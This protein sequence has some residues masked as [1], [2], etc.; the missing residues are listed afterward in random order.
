MSSPGEQQPEHLLIRQR[1]EKASSLREKGIDPFAGKFERTGTLAEIRTQHEK[2]ALR[3]EVKAA[4]RITARRGHGKST[5]LDLHDGTAKLQVNATLDYLGE[6]AYEVLRHLVDIG[7]IVGVTGEIGTTRTGEVTIFATKVR[8]LTKTLRPLPEKFHGLKDIELRHRKRSLDLISN[9]EVID[10]FRTRSRMVQRI[11]VMLGEM[12]FLE[13]ETPMMQTIP[14]GA[15]AR[16]FITHHNTL[17]LDLYMRVSPELYLKRLLVGGMD[18][19]FEIGRNFRNEGISARHNPEFTML[20]LYQAYGD[21]RDMMYITET[22]IAALAEETHGRTSWE[23]GGRSLDFS[24]PWPKID[25]MQQIEQALGTDPW[26]E[27]DLRRK[28][29]DAG[30][31]VDGL[32]YSEL[33]DEIWSKRV[34]PDIAG[35]VFLVRHPVEMSPLCKT[36]PDDARVADRFE[37]ICAGM[38][39]ANAYTELTDPAEQR[40]RFEAQAERRL[41]LQKA[42]RAGGEPVPEFS[43]DDLV[44]E[45][46][47]LALEHGMP[48]AGGLG[49]GIDRLAMI[50]TGQT[51]MREVILFPLLK[52]L[53]AESVP[54]GKP[55]ET[56]AEEG[57]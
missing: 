51:N 36:D 9:P 8:M 47:L 30:M 44:D 13:V 31:E 45:E 38:E 57:M 37:V 48:P 28:A 41:A 6:D 56:R 55:G 20:E 24:R 14:G 29:A 7:D 4:G 34:E 21:L 52:P 18:R 27:D 54:E 40:K 2:G 19:V 33:L 10:T 3:G 42:A 25:F 53:A 49:I 17:A 5:F 16:P 50:L 39:I 22:I 43:S 11:R 26:N 12:G 23:Y 32:T 15:S 46:F 35:P 1:L